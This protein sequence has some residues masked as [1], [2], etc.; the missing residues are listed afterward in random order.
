[1][2]FS[3]NVNKFVIVKLIASS[4]QHRSFLF[5]VKNWMTSEQ[6]MGRPVALGILEW[7][8]IQFRFVSRE[9]R[10]KARKK[11]CYEEEKNLYR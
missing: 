6:P 7:M 11:H 2:I 8:R 10:K 1:M 5:N 9:K 4:F 3:S